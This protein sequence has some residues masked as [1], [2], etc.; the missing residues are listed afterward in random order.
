MQDKL[1]E[2]RKR[3]DFYGELKWCKVSNRLIHIYEGF[4]DVYLDDGYAKFCVMN[5]TKGTDWHSWGKSEEE[6]FFKTY[7][8]FL[9]L[10]T[11]PYHRYDIYL[12]DKSL[13]KSYRWDTLWYFINKTRRT[14]WGL[15]RKNI[16][17]LEPLDSKNSDLIQLTD[18]LLGCCTSEAVAETKNRLRHKYISHRDKRTK[19]NGEK[20]R[21]INWT[22]YQKENRIK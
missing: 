19:C 3:F 9:L 20:F 12:D 6:R 7:Y 22:P 17:C 11:K 1:S 2:V 10:N 13:Q 15:N 5:I 4:L 14:Q 16:R 18:L 21:I 8:S